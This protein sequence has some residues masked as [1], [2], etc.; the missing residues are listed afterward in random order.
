HHPGRGQRERSRDHQQHRQGDLVSP[1][2]GSRTGR[3]LPRADL[4]GQ[5]GAHLVAGATQLGRRFGGTDYLYND[6]Y[7]QIAEVKGG[8]GYS[9]DGQE[10]LITPWNTALIVAD[11]V[12]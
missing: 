4:P 7:R 9:A 8:N 12:T 6:R 2:S 5:A 3:R 1:S 11:T 10:F